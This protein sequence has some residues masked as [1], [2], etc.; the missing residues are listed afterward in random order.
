MLVSLGRFLDFIGLAAMVVP[1]ALTMV[2]HR[3]ATSR[4]ARIVLAGFVLVAIGALLS[5]RPLG[6]QV[7]P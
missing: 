1:L 4:E 2:A 6:A 7:P 5:G 3:P